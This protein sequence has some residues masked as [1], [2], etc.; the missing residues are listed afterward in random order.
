MFNLDDDQV[1]QQYKFPQTQYK[2]S[3]SLFIT[4]IVDVRDAT[5]GTANTCPNTMVYIAD[6]TGFGLIVY[7]LQQNRSWR[8]QNKFF[9]PNPHFGTFTIAG[10][11]FDL[12]D[13]IFG[14]AVSPKTGQRSISSGSGNRL[15]NHSYRLPSYSSRPNSGICSAFPLTSYV[16]N[17]VYASLCFY[18]RFYFGHILLKIYIQLLKQEVVESVYYTST[19]SPPPLKTQFRCV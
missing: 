13:G 19:P 10:E 5:P 14:L 9:Y 3:S 7:D 1:V 12:M 2:S 15:P 6:V 8:I 17:L 18:V 4:P 16:Y 11:S